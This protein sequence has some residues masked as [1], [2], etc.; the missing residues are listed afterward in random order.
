MTMAEFINETDTIC[1]FYGKD[2]GSYERHIWFEEIGNLKVER[3]KEII[4]ECFRT[5][6]FMPKLADILKIKKELPNK[7]KDDWIPVECEKCGSTGIIT[8][9]KRDNESG[10]NYLYGARC[11]C[12]NGER[13]GKDI[14]SI[15]KIN[16]VV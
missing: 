6:K 15:N 3:Y 2:I 13:L 4:R 10:I 7:A 16:I 11:I 8:Y 5:E 1:E 12:A 9:H 14:P